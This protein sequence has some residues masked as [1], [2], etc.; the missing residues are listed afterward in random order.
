MYTVV[1]QLTL[2]ECGYYY[3]SLWIDFYKKHNFLLTQGKGRK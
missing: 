2:E 3:I 1:K